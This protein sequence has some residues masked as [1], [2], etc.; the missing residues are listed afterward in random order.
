L[1]LPLTTLVLALAPAS[2]HVR[3]VKTVTPPTIDGRLDDAA[4]KAAEIS[5]SFTQSYPTDGAAP[6]EH[7]TIRV[8]YDADAVYVGVDCE[9]LH[10]PILERLTRRDRDSESEWIGI[11][12]DPRNEGKVAFTFGVNVAGV[13]VDALVTPLDWNTDWD[14]NW[15]ARAAKTAQGWSAEFRIPFRVLRFDT[16]QSTQTWTFQVLRYIAQKQETDQWSYVPRDLGNPLSHL[17]H[18][19][20]LRDLKKGSSLELRPFVTG[21]GRRLEA[22][23]QTSGTG[24][25][26]AWSAGL[27]LKWHVAQDLTLDAAAYP[28]FA[29]VEADQVILNLT[30]YETF[31][32]EKRPLFLEGTDVFAFPLQVFYSRRIGFAPTLPTLL[33]NNSNGMATET[34]VNVPAP[35]TIYGAAKLVGRVGSD[36]TVGA[37]SAVTGRNEV[38]VQDV[39]TGSRS[40]RLVAPLTAYNALRLRRELGGSGHIGL[41]ATGSTTFET[42]GDY[43]SSGAGT[44][45]ELCPSGTTPPTGSRCFRDSYVVGADALW[46]SPS[47]DYVANGAFIESIIH[48]GPAAVQLDGTSI[49][50]GA[51]APG[52]WVRVAKD[53]GKHFIASASYTGAGR[54]LDYNDLGFMPRQNLH[55][56]DA[57]LGYRTLE[58][59]VLTIETSSAFAV[60]ERRSLTG[61]DLGQTFELNTRFKL[62]SFWTAFIAAD[63]APSRFDD[64]EVGTGLALE[65]AGYLGA[66]LDLGTDP[67]RLVVV[68]LSTQA[69][70]IQH[71]AQAFSAQASITL[72]PVPQFDISLAPLVTWSSGEPRYAGV[73]TNA[74][75]GSTPT[76][77]KLDASS[78]GATLRANYTFAPRLS[79]QAYAQAFLA[80][81]NFT[82]LRAPATPPNGR[83]R[84]SDIAAA[85]AP[86]APPTTNPDFEQAALNLN[87]VLRW[88][89]RLGSTFFLVY[90]RSQVPEIASVV[91]PVA[92][93]PRSLGTR[94]SADV[95]LAKLSYWWAN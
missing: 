53:G 5:D 63:V 95:I 15:E 62:K 52:G 83:V 45:T 18:L 43:P 7:T 34:L 55:E 84:L 50:A 86:Q 57:S 14:E 44:G 26:A 66:Q 4:W 90:S 89:Y 20:D 59:G 8:L 30:N 27:D 39:A 67:K 1:L 91:E 77:G 75:G 13:L 41:I 40:D 74:A 9:Q 29:Q 6:S 24:Y 25:S 35:A 76:F 56:V 48:G 80:A 36:W 38:A 3:A 68:G 31:L 73:A 85:P 64:R 54:T 88:E 93:Q 46:R 78:V 72:S 70:A 82:D 42:A 17:G 37:L 94:A 51:H 19:D 79:L 11:Q 58:P 2:L 69:Q 87:I 16:T 47:G 49:G 60:A 65:R 61:L 92:L 71:D 32:P 23:D 81:G 22:T 33:T 12:L 28:D 10:A 21:Q